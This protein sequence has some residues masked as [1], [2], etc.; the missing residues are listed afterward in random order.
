MNVLVRGRRSFCRITVFPVELELSLDELS[1]LA[2]G[3]DIVL[4]GSEYIRGLFLSVVVVVFVRRDVESP[5]SFP[6]EAGVFSR[7]VVVVPDEV[8]RDFWG[9]EAA[10]DRSVFVETLEAPFETASLPVDVD[11]RDVAVERPSLMNSRRFIVLK[12]P[13][14]PVAVLE[15][16]ADTTPPEPVLRPPVPNPA[17][18]SCLSIFGPGSSFRP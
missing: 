16:L 11:L 17:S 2:A 15:E 9:V 5:E 8:S 10:P 12:P 4:D 14:S 7:L 6:V 1:D 13:V 18:L 3:F